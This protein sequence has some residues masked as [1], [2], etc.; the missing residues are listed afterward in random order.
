MDLSKIKRKLDTG[1]YNDPW[2]YVDDV[3]L[4]F[5]NAFLY[6]KKTSKVYKSCSK[7]CLEYSSTLFRMSD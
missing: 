1:L 3:W 6:N 5:D 7:V 2:E 4:M